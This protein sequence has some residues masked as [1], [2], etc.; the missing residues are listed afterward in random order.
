MPDGAYI[1]EVETDGPAYEAGVQPGDILTR[2][3]ENEIKGVRGY[4]SALDKLNGD[5]QVVLTISRSGRDEYKEIE[6][7]ITV[8]NRLGREK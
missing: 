1:L 6:Y 5:E 4:E 7:P 3:G 2:I 8:M